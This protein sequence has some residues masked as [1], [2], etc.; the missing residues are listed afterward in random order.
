MG[1]A[2]LFE[3][4]LLVVVGKGGVGKTT[5][6]SAL[7]L[8][9][10]HRGFRTLLIEVD[11][12]GRA[13]QLFGVAK[14]DPG[15]VQEIS[16]HLFLMDVDGK[17]ALSEYLLLIIPVKRVIQ[18]VLGSRIYQYF[19]AA[20]P[21][22]K[23]LMTIGKIWYEAERV[24]EGSGKR[25][26]DVVVVDAPATGHSLQYLSMP[27]AAHDAF[28]AGLV[29]REAQRIV[30]VLQ[31]PKKT[32]V[33]FVATA[34]EMPV[35]ETEEMYS[36]VRDELKLPAVMLVVNRVHE[37]SVKP[38]D[39]ERLERALA[40]DK[41]N[42]HRAFLEAVARRGREEVGWIGINRQNLERLHQTVSLPTVILPFLFTEEFGLHEIHLLSAAFR[43]PANRR[44]AK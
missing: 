42:P 10:A 36:R 3:R 40:G 33:I 37:E 1:A 32:G 28:G 41:R 26:W 39:V 5:V 12:V 31:D 34:E 27:Q 30:D 23:E 14:R 22:L 43:S 24:D 25:L 35:N 17:A 13:A 6:A 19:V 18:G 2:E 7:A 4:R 11:G 21:G 20:A 15:E 29:R 8:E 38:A 44:A 16:P 9:S